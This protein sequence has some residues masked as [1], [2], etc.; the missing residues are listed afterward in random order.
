MKKSKDF[1]EFLK[2]KKNKE[3]WKMFKEEIGIENI[4]IGE[5]VDQLN[6]L[7]DDGHE[8]HIKGRGDGTIRFG[9]N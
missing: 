6:R 1:K 8:I 4:S 2:E 9:S 3:E 7:E 5:L